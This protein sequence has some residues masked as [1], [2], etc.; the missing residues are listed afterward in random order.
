M[1]AGKRAPEASQE[2]G[3]CASRN[4]EMIDEQQGTA[5]VDLVKTLAAIGPMDEA[6]S[7]C[8]I[9]AMSGQARDE[10]YV[11]AVENHKN[12]QLKRDS[13]S[14]KLCAGSSVMS[15]ELLAGHE[16]AVAAAQDVL[17]KVKQVEVVKQDRK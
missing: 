16:K 2:V 5:M 9:A 7:D 4:R 8:F 14:R 17:A 1:L 3:R 15:V 10:L 13:V 6:E 11:A 12:A